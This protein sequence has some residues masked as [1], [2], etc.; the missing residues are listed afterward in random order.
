[1][2]LVYVDLYM[3]LYESNG[4]CGDDAQKLH[5]IHKKNVQFD[6]V[7]VVGVEEARDVAVL[8]VLAVEC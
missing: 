1:M 6:E 3:Y 8:H 2:N 4:K 5:G 7:V